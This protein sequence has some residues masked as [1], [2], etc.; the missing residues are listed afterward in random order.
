MIA[1]ITVPSSA[2]ASAPQYDMCGPI[3]PLSAAFAM[4]L[5]TTLADATDTGNCDVPLPLNC[6]ARVQASTAGQP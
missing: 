6:T 1:A 3:A 5:S 4:M 2:A